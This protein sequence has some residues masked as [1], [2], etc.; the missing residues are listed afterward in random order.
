MNLE[1]SYTQ[2]LLP[3]DTNHNLGTLKSWLW[4]GGSLS[5][6]YL[7]L[8]LEVEDKVSLKVIETL[9]TKGVFIRFPY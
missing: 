8:S 3:N 1:V 7:S 6:H 5:S 2:Y 4:K 9:A